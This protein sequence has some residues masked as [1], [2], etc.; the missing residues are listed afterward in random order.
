MMGTINDSSSQIF[1]DKSL[2]VLDN[3]IE[4]AIY[5]AYIADAIGSAVEFSKSLTD[6]EIEMAMTMNG[7]KIFGTAPG[8]ITDDSELSLALGQALESDILDLDNIAHWYGRWAGSNPYDMGRTTGHSMNKV[9]DQKSKDGKASIMMEAAK[10]MIKS[11]SNGCLMKLMPL[12]IWCRNLSNEEL[13]TAIKNECMLTHANKFNHYINFCYSYLIK[14]ILNIQE[15]NILSREELYFDLKNFIIQFLESEELNE[16]IK[17]SVLECF[18]IAESPNPE[19]HL[20]NLAMGNIK[21]A[22]SL[23]LHVFLKNVNYEESVAA[24]LKYAGDT[25][26]NAA[27]LGGV[28][29]CY[30]GKDKIPKV[31]RDILLKFDPENIEKNKTYIWRSKEFVPRYSIQKV[32]ENIKKNAPNKLI[33]NVKN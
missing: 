17:L 3:R 4:G 22:F 18:K 5:G 31:Y 10:A 21:I 33:L 15:E 2:T 16:N 1:E 19:L 32:L 8:Q 6:N 30:L 11:Q 24:I 20:Q 26:T 14:K 27:I 7:S 25:D 12:C 28:I 23:T 13:F 29:G 9:R